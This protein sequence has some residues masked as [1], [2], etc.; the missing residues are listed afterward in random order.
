MMVGRF[1]LGY[2]GMRQML[3]AAGLGSELPPAA[4]SGLGLGEQPTR[5][6]NAPI[7]G[8][9]L[10]ITRLLGI[11]A[12]IGFFTDWGSQSTDRR[13][14]SDETLGANCTPIG[15]PGAPAVKSDVSG[16]TA[17]LA[18]VGVPLALA[19]A[20]H[21][22]FQLTPEVN[23][24]YAT[25]TI[26]ATPNPPVPKTT[27]TGWHLDVGARAGAE[28]HFG[29]IGVPQLSL[30]A[31]IGL[32]FALDNTKT[33]QGGTGESKRTRGVFTTT[34]ND[35]PWNIFISNVAALYYF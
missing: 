35:N 2:L 19:G 34:V 26:N 21:F 15:A 22:S 7:I 16:T 5:R 8:L 30:Q 12:G 14:P 33:S 31:G 9:R 10:W 13:C 23:V 1:A 29:F 11:D 25:Q 32:L 20:G 27:N 28:L 24:G 3:I 18:H 4:G 6:V 17:F